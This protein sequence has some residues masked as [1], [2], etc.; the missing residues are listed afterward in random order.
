MTEETKPA[1]GE[2]AVPETK[3]EATPSATATEPKETDAERIARLEREVEA[4]RKT[5]AEWQPKI[6][7]LNRLKTT[8]G[9]TPLTSAPAP[10]DDPL[11]RRLHNLQRQA[12]QYP[13]DG[14]V[15]D[16]LE[17]VQLKLHARERQR[18]IDAAEP[19]FAAMPKD[20]GDR[21]RQLWMGGYAGTPAAARAIAEREQLGDVEKI[22]QD[23]AR[24]REEIEKDK[25]AIRDGR[26]S[27]GS[28]PVLGPEKPKAD[29]LERVPQS[30]W[31]HLDDLPEAERVLWLRKYNAGLVEVVPG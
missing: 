20:I 3:P 8:G 6:E 4:H 17:N 31:D 9:P 27:L 7:E 16:A 21:A 25:K 5:Q 14:T 10:A 18:R 15:A 2:G 13:D 11:V 28:R 23:L 22:R 30:K 26:L 1:G 24:E 19:E 29:G 12:E